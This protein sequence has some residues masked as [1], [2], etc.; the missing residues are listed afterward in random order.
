[1]SVCEFKDEDGRVYSDPSE[2]VPMVGERVAAAFG[3][4]KLGPAAGPL[5]WGAR[6]GRSDDDPSWWASAFEGYSSPAL[7]INQ[8]SPPLLDEL[9]TWLR[10][11][12]EPVPGR[13]GIPKA[14]LRYAAAPG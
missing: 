13:D 3:V 1:M 4:R 12:G 5:N 2:Y 6:G 14:A 9:Y 7:W 10:K 8:M 11:G